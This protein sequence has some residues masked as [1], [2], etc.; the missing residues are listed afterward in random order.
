MSSKNTEIIMYRSDDGSTKIDVRMEEETVWLSQGQM[1]ELFQSSKANISE[2]IKNIFVEGELIEDSVVRNFRTTA[3]DGKNYNVKHYNLDVIISV[4]LAELHAMNH[5]PIY[6]RDWLPQVD[7][8]AERYGKGILQSAGTVSRQA[9]I[10]K[11]TDEY[12]KYRKR[13]SDLPTPVERDYLETLKQTQKKLKGK[14]GGER[15]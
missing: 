6:M 7:D 3:A 15:E 14:T 1:V 13:I 10:E 4:G 2:H 9:A 11:A 12:K 8:F 5:D